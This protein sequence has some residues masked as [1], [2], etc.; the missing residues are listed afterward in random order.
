[1]AT[2]EYLQTKLENLYD[3]LARDSRGELL[4]TSDNLENLVNQIHTLNQIIKANL[5]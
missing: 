4:V 2:T 1:M 3:Q 5:N